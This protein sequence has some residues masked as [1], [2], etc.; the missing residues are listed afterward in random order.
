MN[1]KTYIIPATHVVVL[2]Q[3]QA[4][5][6]ESQG[7]PSANY[8]SSPGFSDDYDDYDESYDEPAFN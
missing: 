7:V 1:K 5:L 3:Q 2:H 6:T 4:I 8:M